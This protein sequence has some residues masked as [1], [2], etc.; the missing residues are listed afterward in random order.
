MKKLILLTLI[1]I[2]LSCKNKDAENKIAAVET[3]QTIEPPFVW[4]GANLYFLLTDRFNSGKSENDTNFNR[5]KK[6]GKL[7][8]FQG[9][10]IKGITQKVK[11]GY[12]SDLGINAIWMTPIVEQIHGATNEGTG[13]SYGFHGYWTKDW[14]KID[15]NFGTK[16]DLHE[17][18]KEAHAKGIRIVLDAVINHTGP[19]TD[20]DPVWPEEWVRTDQQCSYDSYANTISCTLVANLPDIRTESNDDVEL[21]PQMVEKW[22][23][24]GRYEQEVKELDAFFER[25]GYP[26]APR[27]YIMKWLTDYIIEFGIDGYRADTVKHTEEYVWTEFRKECDYAFAEYKKNNPKKV[28]DNNNFYLVGEVYNYGISGGQFFDFGDKKVN[29]FNPPS[30]HSLINFEFKWN[31]KEMDYEPLFKRYSDILNGDLK[32]FGTLNYLSSHDDSSPFDAER[33]KPYVTANKLLLSPG[34]SQVYYGGESARPLIIE[35]TEGDATLRSFMNWDAIKNDARTKTILTHWQK[36]GKFRAKHPAIGAGVHQM[37]TEAPYYFYRSYQKGN[38][39]DLVVIGL[40]LEKG[41]KVIDVSK[42]FEDGDV[43]HDAYSGET[44][45]VENGTLTITSEFEIVL[46][47]RK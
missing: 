31:S 37:I 42:I 39:K 15:P 26:R 14:T 23:A 3:E 43:L 25:T 16:E 22:K 41:K 2:T 27:F 33:K 12:F 10:D 21:P 7:R 1:L 29:Y 45:T 35:G 19:V 38:F 44:A 5:T 32:D 36:L 28:L 4:E 18:V 47:E 40:E 24:E 13:L 8:G 9:G 17:L 11:E 30:F 20:K 46:L 34:T 6:P